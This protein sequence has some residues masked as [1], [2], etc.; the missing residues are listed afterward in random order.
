MHSRI[1]SVP[2]KFEMKADTL[3]DGGRGRWQVLQV[4]GKDA[5]PLKCCFSDIT[6]HALS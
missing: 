6:D 5:M 2:E 3:I 1:I 4:D